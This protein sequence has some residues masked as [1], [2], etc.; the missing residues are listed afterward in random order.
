MAKILDN[1]CKYGKDA[2][3]ITTDIQDNMLTISISDNGDG[4]K[5]GLSQ[6]IL[7]RGERADTAQPGQ[8]IGLSVAVD[9]VSSYGG[10]IKV[11]NNTGK[12]HLSG[13]CFYLTFS[14]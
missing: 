14:Y 4:I 6:L 1:A 7:R 12:P 3:V 8:G 11:I 13:A 10:E 9:I 5:E 2:V